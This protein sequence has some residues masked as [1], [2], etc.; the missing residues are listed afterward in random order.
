MSH[1]HVEF[2]PLKFYLLTV[3]DSRALSE[4]RSGDYLAEA[5]TAG[6]HVVQRRELCRDDLYTI[7][8]RVAQ[9]IADADIDVILITGG[10]GMFPR[11]ITPEAVRVLF[12]RS[13]PGFGELFRSLSYEEIRSSTLQSR[14]EAGMANHTLIFCLPGSTHACRTGWEKIIAP[15]LDP[16]QENCGFTRV[17]NTWNA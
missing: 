6:D 1:Q 16:R 9:A 3:S 15:Q 11:D 14:A 5:I 4:D 2:M 7:R 17:F 12:D 8:A 10:T 13:I